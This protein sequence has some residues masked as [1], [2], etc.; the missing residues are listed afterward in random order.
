MKTL[1]ITHGGMS[2]D[3]AEIA[4]V[5]ALSGVTFPA[6]FTEFLFKYN[7]CHV[8]EDHFTE[9]CSFTGFLPLRATRTASIE[10]ILEGY[11][12]DLETREWLPFAIDSGGWVFVISLAPSTYG[13]VWLDRFNLGEKDPFKFLSPSFEAFID[14]LYEEV[15]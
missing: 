8:K 4:A 10:M 9:S 13:Q 15:L 5:E 1:T 3:R 7:G 12:V 2:L 11:L 6:Y 14:Q